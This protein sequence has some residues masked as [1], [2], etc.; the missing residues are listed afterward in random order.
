MEAA[1]SKKVVFATSTLFA[2]FLSKSA[3]IASLHEHRQKHINVSLKDPGP[4]EFCLSEI[5]YKTTDKP[6]PKKDQAT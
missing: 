5:H 6:A 2:I 1:I 3:T 4:P